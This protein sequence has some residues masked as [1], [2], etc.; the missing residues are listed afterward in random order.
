MKQLLTLLAVSLPL[1]IFSQVQLLDNI[2]LQKQVAIADVIVEGKVINEVSYWDVDHKNIYTVHTLEVSKMHK[3]GITSEIHLVS[4]GGTIGLKSH[5]VRPALKLPVNTVGVFVVKNAPIALEGFPS[6]KPTY[7][8]VGLSQGVYRY[9]LKK[10]TVTNPFLKFSN[11]KKLEDTLTLLTESKAIPLKE[12]DYFK[13]EEESIKKKSVFGVKKVQINALSPTQ[14]AAGNNS[15]VTISGTDFG[16]SLGTVRFKN[17]DDGGATTIE[18]LETNIVS[19]TD[20]EIKIK[21]PSGAGSG[22]VEVETSAGV[23]FSFP[24]LEV[25]HNYITFRYRND[26]IQG[27]EKLE[28]HIHH[29]GSHTP[30]DDE[31][32]TTGNFENGA[33]TFNYHTDFKSNAAAVDAFKSGF[34]PIVCNAGSKFTISDAT[35]DAKLADDN[36][37]SISFDTTDAGVLGFVVGRAYAYILQDTVTLEYFL[38]FY[39]YELDYVF[40]PDI[41]WDFDGDAT[42]FEYDFNA[43]VRHET[44]H[45]AGLGHVINNAE[46]MHYAIGSGPND[47]TTSE[48]IYD[49]AKAKITFDK[50]AFIPSILPITATDFSDCYT[51]SV[52]SP[53]QRSITAYPNPATESVILNASQPIHSVT[54]YTLTGKLLNQINVKN[55]YELRLN[56][57]DMPSGQYFIIVQF[58]DKQ[59]VVRFIKSN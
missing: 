31:I 17:A 35:T 47:N 8:S 43:V 25:T 49:P 51:L 12:V 27:G 46:I 39:Y 40:N 59:E 30:T 54:I 20:T 16:T 42:F 56:V 21:V 41:S 45:A 50:A 18:A 23:S 37:N 13:T 22:A 44:G 19:W 57:N 4:L 6:D 32:T 10:G 36:I 9:N 3:G 58:E 52:V 26:D 11:H 34:E 24:G 29:I 7:K 48:P 5:I 1:F 53:T 14:I 28:Y 38:Y 55:S 33:Y 2:P 15:V